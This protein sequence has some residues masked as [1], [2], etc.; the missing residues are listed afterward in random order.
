M[1]HIHNAQRPCKPCSHKKMD[2]TNVCYFCNNPKSEHYLEKIYDD[3]QQ[4]FCKG[5][6]AKRDYEKTR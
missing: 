6:N 3:T 4:R 5:G 2:L 1:A